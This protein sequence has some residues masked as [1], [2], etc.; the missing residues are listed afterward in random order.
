MLSLSVEYLQTILE[1]EDM[2]VTLSSCEARALASEVG[3]LISLDS[4]QH[5]RLKKDVREPR[6][7]W[8]DQSRDS[9]AT[10]LYVDEDGILQVGFPGAYRGLKADPAAIERV[11]ERKIGDWVRVKASASSMSYGWEDV[12]LNSYGVMYT[13]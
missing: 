1:R 8:H 13:T 9:V 12:T 5:V 10:V 7:G 11:E 6:F 4:G 3:K 2:I